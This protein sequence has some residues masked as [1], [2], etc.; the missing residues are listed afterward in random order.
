[1]DLSTWDRIGASSGLLFFAL[2]LTAFGWQLADF[3]DP[4]LV[5]VDEIVAFVEAHRTRLGAVGVFYALSG[6]SFLWFMGSLRSVLAGAEANQRLS[7][8]TFGSGIVVAGL[9][10]AFSGL[11]LEIIL[12]DF[13]NLEEAGVIGRWVLF[14]A[15]GGL[16]GITPFPRAVFLGAASL[17][18]IRYGGLPRWLGWF[19]LAGAVV[20][21]IGGVDYLAPSDVSLTGH[22]LADLVIFLIWVMLASGILVWSSPRLNRSPN[23]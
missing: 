7:S 14:D 13:T 9:L 3:P 17:V 15:S 2:F 12:A 8:I 16:L 6:M 1:V 23:R 11:Q 21:L 22:S 19:G 20:N 4:G 10:V 5:A 18:I